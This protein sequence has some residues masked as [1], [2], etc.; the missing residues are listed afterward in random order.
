VHALRCH[1]DGEVVTRGA[2]FALLVAVT[3]GVGLWAA[4]VALGWWLL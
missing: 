4:I 1:V 2:L 3:I